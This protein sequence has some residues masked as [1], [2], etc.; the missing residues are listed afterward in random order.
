MEVKVIE[1]EIYTEMKLFMHASG[2]K[3]IRGHKL[4]DTDIHLCKQY[5]KDYC[6]KKTCEWTLPFRCPMHYRCGCQEQVILITG[7][8]YKQLEHTN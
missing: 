6:N 8:D 5:S 7:D 2:L 1:H 4:K 3:K